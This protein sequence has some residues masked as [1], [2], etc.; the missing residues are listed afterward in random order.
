MSEI[1]N[2]IKG[3][4]W[5][6]LLFVIMI[7]AVVAGTDSCGTTGKLSKKER[8]A[9]IE[10]AKRELTAII[11]GTSTKSLEQAENYVNEVS[12]KNYNDPELNQL[13]IQASQKLKK[14]WTDKENQRQK[15]IEEATNELMEMY[16][17]KDNKSAD[18]LEAALNRFK[19][20]NKDLN[21]DTMNNF[22]ARIEKK[23]AGMRGNG[24][25]NPSLKTQL[26][27]SFQD[28]AD[29]SRSGN[30]TQANASIKN[31]LSLF[32]SEDVNV[33][34]ILYKEGGK[35]ID[36]DKPTT[37]KRYL[38]FIKDQKKNANVVDSFKVDENGKI[39]ELDLF[40]K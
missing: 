39:K 35:A 16:E 2:K 3:I 23:I 6:Q 19:E 10:A 7:A 9:Q 20:K 27:N 12:N 38:D 25:A 30:I 22:Y 1:I 13:I 14:A 8:K 28:I 37:I 31:T 40:K 29:A 18:E 17:N 11:N 21:V 5:Q 24:V 15:R 32:A 33:F 36:F 34:I 4:N 26:E